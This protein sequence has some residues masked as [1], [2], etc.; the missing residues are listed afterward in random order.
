MTPREHACVGAELVQ[1]AE[2]V[3]DG[4]AGHRAL[5]RL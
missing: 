5:P 3:G 4:R 2:L 1:G